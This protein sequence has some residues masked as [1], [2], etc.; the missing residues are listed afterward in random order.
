MSGF[1]YLTQHG[2]YRQVTPAVASDATPIA[3]IE[4]FRRF[5]DAL[6]LVLA[7]RVALWKSS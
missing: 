6:H 2:R 3:V 5:F 1:S 7:H 4:S